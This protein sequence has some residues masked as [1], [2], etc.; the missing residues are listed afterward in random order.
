M[1]GVRIER[2]DIVIVTINMI[3][4]IVEKFSFECGNTAEDIHIALIYYI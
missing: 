2:G 3:V 1:D 4:K